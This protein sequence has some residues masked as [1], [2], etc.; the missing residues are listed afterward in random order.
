MSI[1]DL[2]Y[3][4]DKIE[5]LIEQLNLLNRSQT[6]KGNVTLFDTNRQTSR[7]INLS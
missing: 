2:S 5:Q 6:M 3:N 7:Q 1:L 4:C